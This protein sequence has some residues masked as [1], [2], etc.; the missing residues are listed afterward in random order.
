L[1]RLL[2]A[3]FGLAF[4]VA[5][6]LWFLT[7]P[8][9]DDPAPTAGL[10]GD[11]SAGSQVFTAGGCASCHSAPGAEGDAR[12]ILSGGRAFPSDFGTFYAPNISADAAQGIGGWSPSDLYNAMHHGTS[13]AGQHYYPAFPFT[14]FIHAT[15][16]DIAD[17][18]AYLGTLPADATPSKP[19][20][21]GFPFN[22]RAGLGL[23]KL[24]FLTPDWV[25]P[26]GTPELE[27]GRYLVEAL[28]HCGECHT[29]RNLIG[30]LDKSRWLG[31]APNPSGKGNIPNIT[32][33]KLD[34]SDDDILNYFTTGFTPEFDSVGGEMAEV[35]TNL[36]Q[37]PEADLRAIIAYLRS[38]P[39]IQ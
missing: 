5:A 24:L 27:R 18:S 9:S 26:A 29:P 39:A 14:A 36:G 17:L 33:G 35:V 4:L 37:L 22:I 32:P 8:D 2:T 20:D 3:L 12:L 7:L 34:W 13:P 15:P 25:Q 16:Q 19:H 38:V 1:K 10:T 30:G 31:G 11:V 23:W 6:A 28:A 21:V